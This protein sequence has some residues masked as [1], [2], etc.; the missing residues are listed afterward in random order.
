MMSMFVCLSVCLSARITQKQPMAVARSCSGVVG[1]RYVLPVFVKM[2]R[3]HKMA[4]WCVVF[5]PTRRQIT[6]SITAETPAKVCSAISTQ[7]ENLNTPSQSLLS[8]IVFSVTVFLLC[9]QYSLS[10][11]HILA[12]AS[13]SRD[14]WGGHNRRLEIWGTEVP[15]RGPRAEPQ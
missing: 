2:S 9:L 15:Q 7:V 14:Y 3:F 10:T 11:K 8:F 13:I 4:L 5:I 6:T 1:I 12:R